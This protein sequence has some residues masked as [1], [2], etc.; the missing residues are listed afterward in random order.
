MSKEKGINYNNTIFY[1][2]ADDKYILR[3]ATS[4]LTIRD[5]CAGAKLAI[6]SS[7]ISAANKNVLDELDINYYEFDLRDKFYQTWQ[8]PMECFYIFVGPELFAKRGYNYSVYIDGDVLCASNPLNG[9][10]GDFDIAGATGDTAKGVFGDEWLKLRK[11]FNLSESEAQKDRINSGVVYFNNQKMTEMNFLAENAILFDDCIKNNLPRKG[12]DSLLTL[13][14]LKNANKLSAKILASSYDFIPFYGYNKWKYPIDDLVFFHFAID[15]PWKDRPYEHKNGK[16]NVYNP[17]VKRWL[18]KYRYVLNLSRRRIAV[19]PMIKNMYY[20]V[21]NQILTLR[22]L[23]KSTI[24]RQRNIKKAPLK[25]YWWRYA[26]WYNRPNEPDNFGD[27]ITGDIV[28]SI[29]GRNYIWSPLNQCD[30][31]GAGSIITNAQ[32]WSDGNI[33]NVWGSGFIEPGGNN[34]C[35]NLIFWGVR[36]PKSI[37]RVKSTHDLSMGDPGILSNLVYRKSWRKNGKIGVVAHFHD[38]DLPIVKKLRN[39]G[40]FLLINPL[41]TPQNVAYQ[42]TACKLILSSSLHGLI[43]ADSFKIP[44]YHVVLSNKVEG[45]DYKFKDYCEGVGK[46][47]VSAS[48]KKIFDNEYLDNLIERYEPIKGLARRQRQLINSFPYD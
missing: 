37:K 6:L 12:D 27:A 46:K 1:S 8:Y 23:K 16:L 39:D 30:M 18:I 3:A 7:G 10:A 29:F 24:T 41:D 21:R 33:I 34:K 19:K 14:M 32:T 17:Y 26:D 42:I 48:V 45:G 36:G 44:N 22:G 11:V 20:V 35:D 28:K 13:W 4:L 15:K 43:F 9:L 38:A 40:R 31:I 47:Y 25:I 2:T 5:Y